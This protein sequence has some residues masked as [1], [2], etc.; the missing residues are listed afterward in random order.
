MYSEPASAFLALG[1]NLGE[2]EA[3]VLEA[4]RRIE[5]SG[6]ARVLRCSSLYETDPVDMEPA[7]G[8]VNAVAE[9]RPLLSPVLLLKRLKTIEKQMGRRGGHNAPREIDIDVVTFGDRVID[10]ADLI[11]PHPRYAS[12]GFVLEPLAEIAPG[13]VCPRH[14][15]G[16]AEMI[17]SLRGGERVARVS[18]R[19]IIPRTLP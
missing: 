18:G 12:R 1:A 4:L 13:F 15:R 11:V 3:A 10:T 2:R 9:V 17:A 19:N 6:A 16:I 8:F 7:P 14:G 5:A